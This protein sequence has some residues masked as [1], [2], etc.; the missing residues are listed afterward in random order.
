[1]NTT[2]VTFQK[3]SFTM[4]KSLLTGDHGCPRY[5][6]VLPSAPAEGWG[7]KLLEL[8]KLKNW[9][10][11]KVTIHFVCAVT[12]KPGEPYELVLPKDWV[13]KYGPALRLGLSVLKV[14]C[15]IGRL[16][17]L[18]IPTASDAKKLLSDVKGMAADAISEQTDFLNSMHESITESMNEQEEL[19]GVAA[20]MDEKLTDTTAEWTEVPEAEEREGL[21]ATSPHEVVQKS[22]REMRDL[23]ASFEAPDPEFLRSGLI[24]AVGPEGTSE[25]VAPE[26]QALYEQ[27]GAACVGLSET[28]LCEMRLAGSTAPAGTPAPAPGSSA[29]TA[30][31]LPPMGTV[32]EAA[33]GGVP[34]VSATAA[35]APPGNQSAVM[36][37]MM[38][39]QTA[40]A[41]KQDQMMQQMME[42]HAEMKAQQA[43]MKAELKAQQ[44]Q[45]MALLAQEFKALGSRTDFEAAGAAEKKSSTCVMQ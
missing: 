11:K 25:M 37:R 7:R 41:A 8:S 23:G 21:P 5:V 44:D 35:S 43:Q 40:Q 10:S 16:M 3:S 4:L 34:T 22:F 26:V 6:C 1:M 17:G 15:G 31:R 19:Q 12:L 28:Q 39:A 42:Q 20:W 18:P 9:V 36:Q 2:L 13:T 38:E 30:R 27:Y 33:H 14:A 24:F 45:E 32:P 29:G